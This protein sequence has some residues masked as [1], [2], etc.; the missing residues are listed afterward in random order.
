MGF[1]AVIDA[2]RTPAAA[3]ASLAVAE[4]DDAFAG[5]GALSGSGSARSRADALRRL[6]ERATAREQDFLARL[7]F[8]ELRQG[9]LEGVLI[10]AV[11]RAANIRPATVRRAAMLAGSLAPRGKAGRYAGLTDDE[12]IALAAREDD[13]RVRAYAR[14]A[15]R[16]RR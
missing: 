10:E 11:A 1:A 4:V 14:R 8:G 15:R 13:E 16:G 7:L 12:A 2:R 3:D 9:A 6:F 5:I